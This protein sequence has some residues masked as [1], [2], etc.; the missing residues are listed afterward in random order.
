MIF[1]LPIAPVIVMIQL[2]IQFC[3]AFMKFCCDP[4]L[5]QVPILS[6]LEMMVIIYI[7]T[8]VT[9]PVDKYR[10]AIR[11]FKLI[12]MC[13]EEEIIYFLHVLH[14]TYSELRSPI[15]SLPMNHK[16]TLWHI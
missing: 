4:C 11:Y 13:F 2:V 7:T 16:A 10:I 14:E 6:I 8:Y 15:C 1:S 5:A 9:E 12:S 3:N